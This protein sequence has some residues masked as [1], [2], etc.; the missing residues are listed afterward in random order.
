MPE[1]DRLRDRHQLVAHHHV[2]MADAYCG[3]GDKHFSAPGGF[4]R[5]GFD[6]GWALWCSLHG[7][8]Y[9]LRHGNLLTKKGGALA[10]P[11]KSLHR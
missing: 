5:Q 2:R 7:G 4:Q 8:Q 11:S 3:H 1:H 9:L 6:S 10:P